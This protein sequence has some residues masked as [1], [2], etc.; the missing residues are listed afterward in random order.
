MTSEG[1]IGKMIAR[2]RDW[3]EER[4]SEQLRKRVEEIKIAGRPPV[5]QQR[6]SA[7][8]A[9]VEDEEEEE[10]PPVLAEPHL[11]EQGPAVIQFHEPEIRQNPKKAMPKPPQ[12]KTTSSFLPPTFCA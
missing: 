8:K 5:K 3:R 6:V 7:A 1:Y 4:E 9:G 12:G 11:A 10:E 2:V